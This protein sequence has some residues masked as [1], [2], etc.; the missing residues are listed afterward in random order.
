VDVLEL[1]LDA[2][3]NLGVVS[4][5]RK[6]VL[7]LAIELRREDLFDV[8]VCRQ[9]YDW[10]A[11]D[12]QGRTLVHAAVQVRSSSLLEKVLSRSVDADVAD[13]NG[14]TPLHIAAALDK[15]QDGVEVLLRRGC[16]PWRL[17]KKRQNAFAVATQENAAL[18]GELL[19]DGNIA[20][21]IERK[22]EDEQESHYQEA[23]S[24]V[25]EKLSLA[26]AKRKNTAPLSLD[27]RATLATMTLQAGRLRI[28][29]PEQAKKV[30]PA[31]ARPWGGSRETEAF[32]RQVRLQLRDLRR[33]ADA[34]LKEIEDGIAE[35]KRELLDKLDETEETGD[36]E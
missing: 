12:A 9:G 30:T 35:L 1:V 3:P 6:S 2:T 15:F 24:R 34:A 18:M 25:R 26:T 13:A 36:I 10:G 8:L 27:K 4:A 33:D 22:K 29:D 7:A 21:E 31:V 14:D 11:R 17:N 5:D 32:Q 19:Q 28:R 20:E 23:K 16:N